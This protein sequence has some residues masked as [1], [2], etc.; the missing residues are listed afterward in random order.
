MNND[1]KIACIKKINPF[2]NFMIHEDGTVIYD[3]A[4]IGPMPAEAE[5]ESVLAEVQS[6][7]TAAAQIEQARV[8]E[9]ESNPFS[10]LTFDQ[11]ETWIDDNVTDLQSA[12]SAMK[13]IVRLILART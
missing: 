11:A 6:E 12:K 4:H 3:P 8:I 10:S 1:E 2:A 5:C 9:R 13:K 7:I